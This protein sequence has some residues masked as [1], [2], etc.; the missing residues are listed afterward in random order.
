MRSSWIEVNLDAIRNNTKY[1]KSRI[2]PGAKF[3]AAVKGNAY[4]YGAVPVARV[5]VEQG[6]DYLGVA[7]AEEGKELRENGIKVPILV[8]GA[9]FPDCYDLLFDYDL[10]P[11]VFTVEAAEELSRMAVAKNTTLT[12]HVSIDTG[13]SRLGFVIDVPHVVD[14]IE[15]IC[16]MPGLNVEGLFSM[17]ADGED[18]PNDEYSFV[19]M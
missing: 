2:A 5:F 19:Q 9:T 17:L 6:A 3:L 7:I 15:K 8:F 4:G 1:V 12:I 16:K 11:N 10:I 14:D 13:L 18:F